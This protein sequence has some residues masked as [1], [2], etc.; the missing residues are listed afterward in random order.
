MHL[1][2]FA[3]AALGMCPADLP[4]VCGI[5][6]ESSRF[7]RVC[8]LHNCE[9]FALSN[10]DR[11]NVPHL[12]SIFRNMDLASSE[13]LVCR[14]ALMILCR[15]TYAQLARASTDSTAATCHNFQA[16][17]IRDDDRVMKTRATQADFMP[18][19]Y[20]SLA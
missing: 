12:H 11:F 18:S 3:Q 5:R 10:Q 9:K 15:P 2:A 7:T 20:K 14:L 19:T 17:A 6:T 13:Q 1:Q 16:D 8:C 4:Y